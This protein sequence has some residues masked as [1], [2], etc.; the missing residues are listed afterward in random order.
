MD[1]K[2]FIFVVE[3][4]GGAFHVCETKESVQNS[5]SSHANGVPEEG[6][7]EGVSSNS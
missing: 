7:E 2:L 4:L 1:L 3:V 6:L 5:L